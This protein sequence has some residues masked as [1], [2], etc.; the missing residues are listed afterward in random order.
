MND[1]S[2]DNRT[3]PTEQFLPFDKR[4][5]R[6]DT[7]AGL[8]AAAVVIPKA[9]AYAT[10]AGLPVEIGLYTVL[11]RCVVPVHG[12]CTVVAVLTPRPIS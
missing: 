7:V 2:A 6:A 8:V 1:A 3:T 5:L 4:W 11:V 12:L 9:M 10:I